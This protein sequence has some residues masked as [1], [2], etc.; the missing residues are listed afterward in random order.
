[1]QGVATLPNLRSVVSH[2]QK[3]ISSADAILLTGDLVH[4]EKGGYEHY[5]PLFGGLDKPVLCLPGNHD[6]VEDMHEV[7]GSQ[8]GFQ[9]LGHCD[10]GAAWRIIMIN[11]QIPGEPN[12]RV[13]AKQLAMLEA[14]LAETDK[15]KKHALIAMHHPPLNLGSPW[16]DVMGLE[17]PEDLFKLLAKHPSAKALVFGHAHQDFEGQIGR[18]KIAGT[19]STSAQFAP[20][21]AKFKLDKESPGYR[22]LELRA[23]GE[24]VTRL[25]RVPGA[26]GMPA[27]L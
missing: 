7:L 24:M 19:P 12:G 4:D 18:V 6:L 25:V 20:K 9:I 21:S 11:T 15:L 13:G 22:V 16:L 5:M 2:G 23:D 1:M 10:A 14:T 17:D 8:K 26:E 3:D 27:N